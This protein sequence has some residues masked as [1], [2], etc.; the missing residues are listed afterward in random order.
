[1]S[2]VVVVVQVSLSKA[3]GERGR[4]RLLSRVKSG[5]RERERD[6]NQFYSGFTCAAGSVERS[7]G[8]DRLSRSASVA[9]CVVLY[10]WKNGQGREREGDSSRV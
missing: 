7:V 3:N 1:M 10:G 4:D 9:V 2:S 6:G 5:K 8:S